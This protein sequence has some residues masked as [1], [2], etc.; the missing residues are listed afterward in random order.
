[1]VSDE[2]A[3]PMRIDGEAEYL[4][5]ARDS[6]R[7]DPPKIRKWVD[8]SQARATRRRRPRRSSRGPAM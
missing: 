3:G 6:R 4:H 5:D 7:Y 1:M 2:M 8:P